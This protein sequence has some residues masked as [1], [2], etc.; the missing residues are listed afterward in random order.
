MGRVR[1]YLRKGGEYGKEKYTE[2]ML[3]KTGLKRK[4]VALGLT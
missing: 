2:I 1:C 3:R 4:E